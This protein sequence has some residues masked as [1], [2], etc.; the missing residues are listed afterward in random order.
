MPV[1]F[2]FC[3]NFI[4]DV[5]VITSNI[6]KLKLITLLKKLWMWKTLT[7]NIYRRQTWQTKKLQNYILFIA[8]RTVSILEHG[9]SAWVFVTVTQ[10]SRRRF[11]DQVQE[12]EVLRIAKCI[13]TLKNLFIRLLAEAG[14]HTKVITQIKKREWTTSRACTRLLYP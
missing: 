12:N 3:N 10:F 7:F 14:Q 13:I 1:C 4:I 2:L 9:L 5:Q 11:L 6:G 8:T